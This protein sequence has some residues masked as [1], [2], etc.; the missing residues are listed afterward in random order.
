[1]RDPV[2]TPAWLA[3]RLTDPAVRVVDASLHMPDSGR[4]ARAEFLEGRI[5]GAAFFDIDAIAAPGTGL[6]HMLPAPQ[7]FADAVGAMGI[8]SA[9]TVVVYDTVGLFSAPRLWW[10]FRVFGH[11]AVYVLDGGLPAWREAG[12]PLTAG[13]C[14][15]PEPRPFR[16]AFR[17]DLLRG[18][19]DMLTTAQAGGEQIVDAR[20]APRFQGSVPEP[21]PGLRAGHIPGSRNVPF[22]EVLGPG[23]RTLLPADTLE[24]R[25][26]AAGVDLSQPIATSCGSGITACILALALAR[27]GRT[28]VAVY[29]GSWTEW[30]GRPDLP[31]ETGPATGGTPA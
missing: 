15:P 19:L 2:V 7:V 1:M 10:E 30:G 27:L 5:P 3:D 26:G 17:P 21:R 29:D 31:V 4:D 24:R 22:P 16:A 20:P 14:H 6:P 11:D 8:G 12:L 28:D 13:P 25:F 23:F 9:D 18:V